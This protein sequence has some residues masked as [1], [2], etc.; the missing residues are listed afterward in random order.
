MYFSFRLTGLAVVFSSLTFTTVSSKQQRQH[1]NG[2]HKRV[3]GGNEAEN[4]QFP[5]TVFISSP[6]A[7]ENTGCAG[8]IL[9]DQIIL[10]SAYCVYNSKTNKT[11]DAS[12]VS[13]GYGNVNTS[14]QPRAD[15]VK[16]I[17]KDTYNATANIDDI[18]L[19]QVNL[20]SQV[21]QDVNRIPV[22][23]GDVHEKDSLT[24]LGWGLAQKFGV[25]IN[26]TLNY[27][28][29]TVGDSFSCGGVP[30]FQNTNGRAVC[31]RNKLTDGAG[32]CVGDWGGPLITYDGGVAKLV[33]VLSALYN[34]DGSM[35]IDYC[36][37]T[38]TRA[39]YT[40]ISSY[41]DFLKTTTGLS[42]NVFTGNEPL[43]SQNGTGTAGS[44]GSG[45]SKGAIAGISIAAIAV[46]FLMCALAFALY[47]YRK[48]KHEARQEQRIYELGLQQLADELG[49]SYEPKMSSAMSAFHSSAVTP[50][51]DTSMFGRI[52]FSPRY[53]RNTV[54]SDVSDQPFSD[55]IP[56]L[57]DVGTEMTMDTLGKMHR[58]TDGSPKVLDYIR[59]ERDG[60]ISSYYLH[61]LFYDFDSTEDKTDDLIEL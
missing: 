48:K 43:A 52:S 2:I 61:L 17:I 40:H 46:A 26:S 15:V 57:A 4:S 10:T 38:D 12:S 23:I 28:N 14:K 47:L 45:L 9:T 27:A 21:S 55:N 44:S 33:G 51:D 19:I 32:P 25:G 39:Y 11:V 18:A 1:G 22:Y 34:S 41:M 54:Y 7:T 29:V 5:Y 37:N 30:M 50:L 35:Q 16:I 8:A 42:E 49:G 3:Y 20:S 24:S 56:K 31:T 13:I 36:G 60:K 59:P 53:L 6:D 58:H